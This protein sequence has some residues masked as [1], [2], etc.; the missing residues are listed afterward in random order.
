[1]T[2]HFDLL[3]QGLQEWGIQL[4]ETTLLKF[5]QYYSLILE[6]NNRF[7]IT[8]ITEEKELIIKHFMDSLSAA[9]SVN[10]QD[11]SVID[12]GT[13]AGFPGI[14]LGL[15]FK[16]LRITFVD[17]SAKKTQFVETACK[18]LGLTQYHVITDNIENISR[19]EEHREGYDLVVTRAVSELRTLIE[20]S[21][22]LLKV[23]GC[24]IAY[25]GPNSQ[26][27]VENS[28]NALTELNGAIKECHEMNLPFSDYKRTIL[29]VEKLGKTL[30][31]YPRRVG[32][33]KK[34]PL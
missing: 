28:K 10:F 30:S 29:I 31:K 25:K 9:T 22:P 5:R 19:E 16:N 8:A 20:Y 27:E 33:P 15:L 23:S 1:M 24:L 14:P 2:N 3:R 17:S 26:Q 34:R 32:I 18:A 4:D 11:Q 13:G 21:L 6:W 12:I 7:N